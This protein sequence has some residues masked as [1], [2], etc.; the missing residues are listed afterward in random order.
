MH[1]MQSRIRNAFV[2]FNCV[3]EYL[4][5][6]PILLILRVAYQAILIFILV[7]P[8]DW[9]GYETNHQIC[10]SI[11]CYLQPRAATC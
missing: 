9:R 3:V 8:F 6:K 11:I 1:L 4:S 7:K 2:N 10:F 5:L